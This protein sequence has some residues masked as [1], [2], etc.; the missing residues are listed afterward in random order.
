VS[1]I[2]LSVRVPLALPMTE[3]SPSSLIMPLSNMARNCFRQGRVAD[4]T[5]VCVVIIVMMVIAILV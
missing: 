5:E 1:A 4:M 2:E 3:W